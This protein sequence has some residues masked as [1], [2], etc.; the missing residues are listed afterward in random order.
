MK[1]FDIQ[2]LFYF[3]YIARRLNVLNFLCEFT[4]TPYALLYFQKSMD[5]FNVCLSTSLHSGSS[6]PIKVHDAGITTCLCASSHNF[7]EMPIR[8]CTQLLQGS[9]RA[10]PSPPRKSISIVRLQLL[11]YITMAPTSCSSVKHCMLII[12]SMRRK[13][14]SDL[15]ALRICV[16]SKYNKILFYLSDLDRLHRHE[17]QAADT[18]AG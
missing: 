2:Q 18:H 12:A 5:R 17:A 11:L 7:L 15:I 13:V 10:M 1:L 3:H 8:L 9:H 6:G 14:I 4:T 16:Y